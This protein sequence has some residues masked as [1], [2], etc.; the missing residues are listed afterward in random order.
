MA[1]PYRFNPSKGFRRQGHYYGQMENIEF[2][3]EDYD[4]TDDWF[5]A[6]KEHFEETILV[7]DEEQEDED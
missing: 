4:S 5:E 1:I 2:D 6:I 3:S 7:P